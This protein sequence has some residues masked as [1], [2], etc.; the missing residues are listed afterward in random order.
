[1]DALIRE[2]CEGMESSIRSAAKDTMRAAGAAQAKIPQTA[3]GFG[4]GAINV[5]SGVVAAWAATTTVDG[6]LP[7]EWLATLGKSTADRIVAAGRDAMI[8]GLG[9]RK[10]A[11]LLREKGI[12]GSVPGLRNLA[13]TFLMSASNEARDSAVERVLGDMLKEWR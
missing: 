13:R 8:L 2:T 11:A 5:T 12:N 7:K 9:T 6:L 1:M 4:D 3:F 10:T